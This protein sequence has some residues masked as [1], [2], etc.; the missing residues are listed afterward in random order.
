MVRNTKQRNRE[1]RDDEP[2]ARLA[3]LLFMAAMMSMGPD[4]DE[5]SLT[6]NRM[7]EITNE[8]LDTASRSGFAQGVELRMLI[9]SGQDAAKVALLVQD[10]ISVIPDAKLVDAFRKLKPHGVEAF[11]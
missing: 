11:V 1:I 5:D 6:R 2:R 7:A 8:I 3:V 10:A 4:T 9:A